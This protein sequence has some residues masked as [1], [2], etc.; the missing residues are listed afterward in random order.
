[1]TVTSFLH[2]LSEIYRMFRYVRRTYERYFRT[3]QRLID[4]LHIFSIVQRER[5]KFVSLCLSQAQSIKLF[6]NNC[7]G[8]SCE[9][10]AGWPG[11]AARRQ[12]W[13]SRNSLLIFLAW[14]L[15]QSFVAETIILSLETILHKSMFSSV[16]HN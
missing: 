14:L 6:D 8:C 10:S 4:Y 9:R 2:V 11:G 3:F 1:M 7:D 13:R 5:I 16:T 15:T 12:Q